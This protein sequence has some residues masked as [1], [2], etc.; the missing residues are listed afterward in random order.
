VTELKWPGNKIRATKPVR[1]PISYVIVRLASLCCLML[2]CSAT[3]FGFCFAP[4]PTVACQFLNSDAVFTGKVISVRPVEKDD[5]TDGYYYRLSVIQMFRG[6]HEKI[7]EVYT[8]NDS[9]GYYLDSGKEYLIFATADPNNGELD[10]SNC[11]DNAPLAEAGKLI[12]EIEKIKV[13]RDGII[14]GRI[15]LH[16]VPGEGVSGVKVSI[17]GTG[18]RYTLSTDQQGWFRVQV[19]HGQ[20]SINIESTPAREIEAFDLNYGGKPQ[21]FSVD[22]G[23]CAGFE[24]IADPKYKY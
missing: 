18:G 10:I 2:L 9:G 20:Y 19:P 15:V 22:A 8:G 14:E 24:F 3:A 23:K 13:P 17:S 7:V 12:S 11:D 21:L 4:H 1:T 6:S 5:S 16:Q